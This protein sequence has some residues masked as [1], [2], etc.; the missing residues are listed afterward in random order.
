M[1]SSSQNVTTNKPIPSFYRP[2]A[3]PVAQPTTL[4]HWGENSSKLTSV[5]NVLLQQ[6]DPIS[7]TVI[8][9]C[10]SL[11]LCVSP[12][13]FHEYE[14][15]LQLLNVEWT[16]RWQKNCINAAVFA[17]QLAWKMF[18]PQHICLH[19]LASQG[20]REAWQ[21]SLNVTRSYQW[22]V[23]KLEDPG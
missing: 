11:I 15:I 8:W 23:T 12:A 9:M 10:S 5:A 2:D 21:L 17:L 4:K 7:D 3:L 14:W 1:Q 19:L 16:I 22:P 20:W 13:E 6:N 18:Y